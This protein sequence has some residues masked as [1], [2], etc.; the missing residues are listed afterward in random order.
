MI[1][2][3]STPSA[4]V[5]E[6]PALARILLVDDQASNLL[7]LEAILEPLGQRLVTAGS[8]AEALRHLLR[9]DFALILLDVQMP[10]LDGFETARL[11]RQRERTR[12]TP[13]IFLTAY[14]GDEAQL[15]HG[16][17]VGAADYV[18][19]PF[20]PD[21]LRWKVEVF[22]SLFQQQQWLQRHEA[23]LG[24]REREMLARQSELRFRT[25]VDSMPQ[26][27]WAMLPDGTI[28][29]ANRGW[30]EYAGLS[31]QQGRRMEENA[32]AVHPEDLPRMRAGWDASL[33]TGQ[34]LEVEYRLRRARDGAFRWFLG[35]T[36]P[37]RDEEGQVVGWIST[38]TDIDDARRAVEELRATSEAKDMFLTMAAHELRTPLQAARSYAHLARV[39]AGTALPLGVDR[40]LQG[41]ARSVNRMASLVENLL[42]TGRLERGELRLEMGIVDLRAL[43]CEVAGHFQPLSDGQRIEVDAPQGLVLPGDPERLDQVFTNLVSNALRYSPE[44]ADVLLA[45]VDEGDRVHVRVKD[46]G[47]GIPA[48][49]LE[50]IFERFNRAHGIS[51]G[52]LGLGLAIARGIVERHGGRV[53]AES[54]GRPGEGSTFHVVL[55][56]ARH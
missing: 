38:A 37:E 25:L 46:H 32:R 3:E 40:A 42:D 55:P 7:A 6:V 28:T 15:V 14:T 29:Y 1:R 10:D 33:H 48:G 24:R 45:A 52:G 17:A 35:R 41:V 30:L 26:F 22:V 43:L 54:A 19:K 11:I 4:T 47:L 9:E 23:E 51:Y 20:H 13:I 2:S 39:K 44:G 16:Y 5:H 31:P 8:G 49:R 50:S 53:W 34:T 18:V 36:Q 21:V 56:R 12:Y 27:V